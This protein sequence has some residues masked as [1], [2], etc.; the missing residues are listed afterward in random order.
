MLI[1]LLTWLHIWCF[2]TRY[3]SCTFR[4]RHNCDKVNDHV[5]L[6]CRSL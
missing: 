4:K 5:Y 1:Q 2:F 3:H 6:L